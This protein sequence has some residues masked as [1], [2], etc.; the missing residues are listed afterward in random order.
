MFKFLAD[1]KELQRDVKEI[2]DEFNEDYVQN[3]WFS[4]RRTLTKRV[5]DLE[6]IVDK[7]MGYLKVEANQVAATPDQVIEGTPE[8]WTIEKA[9]THLKKMEA[10]LLDDSDEWEVV[11]PVEKATKKSKKSSK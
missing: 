1:I 9:G 3:G 7:L 8:H 5:D 10:E 11:A 2:F 6:Q 4:R